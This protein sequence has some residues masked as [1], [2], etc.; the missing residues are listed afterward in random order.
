MLV[1]QNHLA[2]LWLRE[3]PVLTLYEDAPLSSRFIFSIDDRD[4]HGV[5]RPI[6]HTIPLLLVTNVNLL[7]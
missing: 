3:G 2:A 1:H 4:I 5:A 6:K 7:R